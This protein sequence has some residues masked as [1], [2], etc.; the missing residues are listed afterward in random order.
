M[1]GSRHSVHRTRQELMLLCDAGS[2]NASEVAANV[3]N[4]DPFGGTH[5]VDFFAGGREFARAAQIQGFRAQTWD[6][7]FDATRL[8]L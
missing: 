6:T 7:I 2:R 3:E 1:L 5:L 8:T 4:F